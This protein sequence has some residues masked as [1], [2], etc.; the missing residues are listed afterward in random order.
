MPQR[1][2]ILGQASLFGNSAFGSNWGS[3]SR[4]AT[5]TSI[6]SAED[7]ASPQPSNYSKDG[8]TDNGV[9]T[10][11]YLGLA[12]TPSQ[13]LS[14]GMLKEQGVTRAPDALSS[15]NLRN[16]SRFRS[17]SVN[18][19]PKYGDAADNNSNLAMFQSGALTPS[20]AAALEAEYEAVQEKVRLHNQAVQAFAV[21]ASAARPRAR[22]AGMVETP[23][24]SLR[25][26]AR[27]NGQG[28]S[29]TLVNAAGQHLGLDTDFSDAMNGLS[30][31]EGGVP[32][33]DSYEDMDMQVSR[34]LWI[35]SIPNSTTMSSLDAI[36]NN[37]GPIESTRV[38]TH[39]NCGFVNFEKVDHAVRARQILNGKEIFPGAGPVRIG[40]AKAPTA[41]TSIT[42]SGSTMT[43][44]PME[45]Q[46]FA[47][48]SQSLGEGN[49][50]AQGFGAQVPSEPMIDRLMDLQQDIIQIVLDFGAQKQDLQQ[51]SANIHNAAA[52]RH[53]EKEVPPVPEPSP[54]R[55][56]DAPRLRDIRKRID[57]GTCG[58]Q[59]IEQIALDMLPE[60]AELA[61]DYLGNTVVQKLFEFTSD[62]TKEQMLMYI[63]PHLAEIGVHKNGTW[64]AQKIIDV[65]RT[66]GQISLIVEHLR[67]YT[68]PL[69]LDQYGNYV[70]QCCLKFGA[71]YNDF[72]F[73][74]MLSQIWEISQGRFGSR[75]MRAC[76]ES[77]HA[78]KQQ[79]RL[80]A[81][82]I[83][84][85]SV[86][87]ATSAN[88]ALLLTW[89]LDTCT[90]PNRRL[91]LAPRLVA[92]LVQ[93]CTHKVA[94][95]TVLKV[96][97]QR[98]EPEARDMILRA[99]FFST[100]D[101]ILEQIL[102]DQSSG[103]TLIFKILTSPFLGDSTRPDV[104]RNISKVLTNIRAQGNQGYKRLM[105]EV[106]MASRPMQSNTQHYPH[107]HPN[108]DRSRPSTAPMSQPPPYQRQYSG[109]YMP[110]LNTNGM[111]NGVSPAR[112][113][114]ADSLGYS[115]Y[116][117]GAYG[118]QQAYPSMQYQQ[119]TPHAQYHGYGGVQR[120][121]SGPYMNNGFGYATP[122]SFVDPFRMQ[123]QAASPAPYAAQ[124]SPVM[125]TGMMP[126][127][128]GQG[129]MYGYPQQQPNYY[130]SPQMQPVHAAGRGRRV[131]ALDILQDEWS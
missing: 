51:V 64:A 40:F 59:E 126:Q 124:M 91:V 25:N 89:L 45:N 16:A 80:M 117:M 82:A 41:S 75:A 46:G 110:S 23:Q 73:E 85:Q 47:K 65:C 50:S 6:S 78:T 24:R 76:L 21:N 118:A 105:D 18:T 27:N 38:L 34:S 32:V 22:T 53:F 30:L 2:S 35:G 86:Q 95:L 90:F 74:T 58:L 98:T 93:L 70:L 26:L 7:A 83:A 107:A 4:A 33:L 87:L 29:P 71:P 77:H 20:A 79:Q 111:E 102:K 72:I 128:Y 62:Q 5:L 123:N 28:L 106:G 104:V 66:D 52:F 19:Q 57:N 43:P 63:A 115:A 39:K 108:I 10:L 9:R 55:L 36:F 125:G 60:I 15:F 68:V 17:F 130:Y 109:T 129:S 114:S 99:L 97:N 69:F 100:N 31:G 61:S 96:I 11:D 3:R 113:D 92:H 116:N 119:M 131:S 42:P 49:G 14:N 120:A 127:N 122:P 54:T 12:E 13:A 103:V 121:N 37:Y 1:S 88:G 44:A 94:Y 101:T 67:P 81:A 56:Y 8:M 84:L 48:D 112:S